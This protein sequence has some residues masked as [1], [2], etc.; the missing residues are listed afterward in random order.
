MF[1]VLGNRVQHTLAALGKQEESKNVQIPPRPG[2]HRSVRAP[3]ERV[4]GKPEVRAEQRAV[5]SGAIENDWA[6]P[7]KS[8]QQNRRIS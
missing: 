5:H 8:L 2:K 1:Y 4:V 3:S 7:G 6:S